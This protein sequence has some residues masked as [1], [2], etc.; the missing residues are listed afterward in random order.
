MLSRLTSPLRNLFQRPFAEW[1]LLGEAI[2]LLLWTKLR[3]HGFPFAQLAPEL[4]IRQAETLRTIPEADRRLV[5]KISW[6]VLTGARYVPLRLVCLPQAMAA[7]TM[8]ARRGVSSTLYLGVRLDNVN[9]LTAH[10][11]LRAGGKWVTGND[12][13][14]GQ[15]T[16][17]C[18]AR[19]NRATSRGAGWRLAL[20]AGV[21]TALT[22]L[23]LMP[24][25]LLQDAN[26]P[27]HAGWLRDL[28]H[29]MGRYDFAFNL[30][31]MFIATALLNLALYGIN[32]APWR[33]R[34]QL[35]AVLCALVVLLECAQLALPRRNF[36]PSDIV[37]GALGVL[38][39]ALPWMRAAAR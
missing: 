30:A 36:D 31:G 12:A 2:M 39:A 33:F 11:W 38:L 29:A 13:R 14:R 1:L 4:G 32:R 21:M 19:I 10:A 5:S 22:F 17:G 34:W 3:L 26:R 16:V 8:L 24:A 20:A 15:T 25:P 23:T 7:G 27:G 35:P 6:A 18:F 9:A 37:A 28:G